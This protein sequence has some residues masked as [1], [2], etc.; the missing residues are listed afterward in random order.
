MPGHSQDLITGV[1]LDDLLDSMG[2]NMGEDDDDDSSDDG[3]VEVCLN[4]M[5]MCGKQSR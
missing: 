3:S 4:V 1:S 2:L 5:R